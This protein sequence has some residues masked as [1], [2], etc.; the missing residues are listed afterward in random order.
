MT[1][2]I[3]IL[4]IRQEPFSL[5]IGL[6]LNLLLDKDST[7]DGDEDGQDKTHKS[8]NGTQGRVDRCWVIVEWAMCEC[9]ESGLNELRDARDASDGSINATES[10]ETKDFG[11]VVTKIKV[12]D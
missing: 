10:S 12:S 11:S 3:P 4:S 6:H 5:T 7:L 8:S 9:I 2:S 1:C